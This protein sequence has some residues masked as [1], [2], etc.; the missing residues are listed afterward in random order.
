MEVV[1]NVPSRRSDARLLSLRSSGSQRS[2]P[3]AHERRRPGSVGQEGGEAKIASGWPPGLGA[4]S[5]CPL[6]LGDC[7]TTE[8]V[9]A[10]LLQQLRASAPIRRRFVPPSLP[11]PVSQ[12]QNQRW[13]ERPRCPA[14]PVAPER[15]DGVVHASV[16]R[17]P[18]RC[19]ECAAR[20]RGTRRPRAPDCVQVRRKRE[21]VIRSRI[22]FA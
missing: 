18:C 17:V 14:L 10:F 3:S 4:L 21:S 7:M 5:R 2:I 15:R 8:R 16:G 22:G 19:H 9:Q 13:R 6:T 20:A 1:V 12:S 11:E